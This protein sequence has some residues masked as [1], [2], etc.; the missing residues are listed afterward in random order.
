[1]GARE[2][3][4]ERRPQRTGRYDPAVADA[5]PGV[6]HEHREVLGERRIVE[7][8]VHDD[9]ARAGGDGGALDA[10]PRH[11][12]RRRAR[13]QERLVAHVV[14]AMARRI[15]PDR[16]RKRPAVAAA[17]EDRPLA[18]RRQH[19]RDRQRRRRLAGTTDGQIADADHR[20]AGAAAACAQARLRHRAVDRRQRC[21]QG[22]RE[23]GL[24]PPE[25][26][27]THGTR[28]IRDESA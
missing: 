5:A 15:D 11:D 17:K 19:A 2:L 23:G 18:R 28:G 22:R 1:M 8:I 3:R 20:R 7:P 4:I 21:E 16:A 14:R 25:R 12:G 26:R 13:E 9:D 6:D 10:V 24:A 27:L